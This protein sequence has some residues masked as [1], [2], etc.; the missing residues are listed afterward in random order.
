MTGGSLRPSCGPAWG[1][2]CCCS[3]GK[4]SSTAEGFAGGGSSSRR[5]RHATP[6]DWRERSS[7]TWKHAS[8]PRSSRT[9]DSARAPTR[10]Y[11]WQLAAARHDLELSL[12]LRPLGQDTDAPFAAVARPMLALLDGLDGRVD[13]ARERLDTLDPDAESSLVALAEAVIACR[14]QRWKD[15]QVF[16][17]TP[18]VLTLTSTIGALARTLDAWS[19]AEQGGPLEVVDQVALFSEASPDELRAAWPELF[20]FLERAP[21]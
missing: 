15:A 20:A 5:T 4:P 7:C 6:S 9:T 11:L 3:A 21:K 16:V 14:Q 17:R 10:L 13:R 12:T 1:P 2:C 19:L 18:E 8:V